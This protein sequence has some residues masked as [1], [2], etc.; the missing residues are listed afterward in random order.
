[1]WIKGS[2]GI[3]DANEKLDFGQWSK[4]DPFRNWQE[5]D[6]LEN[7]QPIH[8]SK[9]PEECSGEKKIYKDILGHVYARRIKYMIQGSNQLSA[10][11]PRG[12]KR[13]EMEKMKEGAELLEYYTKE[14]G[15]QRYSA[16]NMCYPSRK[17]KRDSKSGSETREI[18]QGWESGVDSAMNS[19]G[20]DAA[21]ED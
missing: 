15:I 13:T 19:G 4:G 2:D 9:N 7:F 6:D 18:F 12:P 10:M 11:L 8:V 5:L 3:S 14:L 21:M 17:E 1:M 20:R 16:A